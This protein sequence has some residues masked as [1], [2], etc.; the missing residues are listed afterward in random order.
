MGE[1]GKG[2]N[3]DSKF[4]DREISKVQ[5]KL[6][7]AEPPCTITAA[8][9]RVNLMEPRGRLHVNHRYLTTKKSVPHN[10]KCITPSLS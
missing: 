9:A 4:V 6:K 10:L 3:G 7:V 5:L 8:C 1:R 2:A